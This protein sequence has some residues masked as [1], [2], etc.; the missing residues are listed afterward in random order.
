MTNPYTVLEEL[1]ISRKLFTRALIVTFMT[2]SLP[3]FAKKAQK[4]VAKK[5]KRQ[6]KKSH[7]KPKSCP[8]VRL[9]LRT[10]KNILTPGEELSYD[11]TAAGLY[12]GKVDIKIGQPGVIEGRKVLPLFGRARTAS[13]AS[14][15]EKFVGRTMSV[16]DFETFR[17]LKLRVES[18]Y[19]KDIRRESVRFDQKKHSLKTDYRYKKRKRSRNYRNREA[20]LTDLLTTVHYARILD[21]PENATA[22]QEIYLDRRLWRM[23]AKMRGIEKVDTV[24]GQRSVIALEVHLKRLPHRD[25]DPKRPRPW[26]KGVF[27]YSNDNDRTLLAFDLENRLAKG[28]GEL[29]R[30]VKKS[31]KKDSAWKF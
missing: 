10:G 4:Q 11:I 1:L 5:S 8:G 31:K 26:L 25:F 21:I 24:V 20:T 12:I 29:T 18:E 27:Y 16:V 19:G 3:S 17:P 23:D 15:F 7:Q 13:F 14:A 6:L 22:C 28:R 30:W 2:M 9:P